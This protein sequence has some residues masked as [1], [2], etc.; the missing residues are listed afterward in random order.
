MIINKSILPRQSNFTQQEWYTSLVEECKAIITEAEFTSRWSIVEG[1]HLL[2]DRILKENENF[3]REKIYGREIVQRVA[4]SIGKSG[5]SVY[6]AVQFAK[7]Y[8]SLDLLP[9][10]KN[11]SWHQI[12][13]KYLPDNLK[14]K[15]EIHRCEICGGDLEA[16]CHTVSNGKL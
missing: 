6:L 3:E 16:S 7:K 8:P 10:G 13:N 5:R 11:T 14:D 15:K 1:Y 12:V 4:N 2:G 9:E